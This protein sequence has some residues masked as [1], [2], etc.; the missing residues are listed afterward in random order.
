MQRAAWAP[1]S[2]NFC[3]LLF[4]DRRTAFFAGAMTLT[5]FEHL[6]AGA[7]WIAAVRADHHHV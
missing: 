2:H 1:H 3:F 7:R 5:V 6:V 4:L